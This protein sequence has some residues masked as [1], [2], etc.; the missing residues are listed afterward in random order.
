MI[1][2]FLDLVKSASKMA[3][4]SFIFSL[5]LDKFPDILQLTG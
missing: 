1:K 5:N 3:K 4:R 2:R